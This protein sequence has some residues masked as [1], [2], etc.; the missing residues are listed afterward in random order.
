MKAKKLFLIILSCLIFSGTLFAEE[1]AEPVKIGGAMW[2]S[3]G[4]VFTNYGKDDNPLGTGQRYDSSSRFLL[5]RGYLTVSKRF[6]EIFKFGMILEAWPVKSSSNPNVT[7]DSGKNGFMPYIKE[8]A[9]T[10][11]KKIGDFSGTLS[12]GLIDSNIVNFTGVLNGDYFLNQDVTYTRTAGIIS[13]YDYGVSLLIDYSKLVKFKGLI[14]Q[15]DGYLN[16]G[17]GNMSDNKY[18]WQGQVIVTPFEQFSIFSYYV[19]SDNTKPSDNLKSKESGYYGAGIAWKDKT[20]RIGGNWLRIYESATP[21]S[22]TAGKGNSDGDMA[23]TLWANVNINRFAG[24]PF[25]IYL[26]FDKYWDKINSSAVPGSYK[27]FGAG[28]GYIF[29]QN[30]QL[31][32]YFDM[33]LVDSK[34]GTS[35]QVSGIPANYL[36]GDYTYDFRA[37]YLKVS[38]NF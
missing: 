1:G 22:G 20:F 25:V 6:D 33:M 23:M 30:V 14:L 16:A 29:N 15:G 28:V 21:F 5:E 19:Y 27:R 4:A 2:G 17:N 7:S 9:L 32:F 36:G 10:A 35:G 31:A 37:L 11:E 3:W 8:F 18:V 24:M 26:S 13:S 12:F 34:D 38:V